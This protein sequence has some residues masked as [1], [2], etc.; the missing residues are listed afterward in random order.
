MIERFRFGF[1]HLN[2]LANSIKDHFNNQLQKATINVACLMST[3]L[4]IS[5]VSEGEVGEGDFLGYFLGFLRTGGGTPTH[6]PPPTVLNS[7]SMI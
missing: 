7:S 5:H 1:Q 3:P 6:H 4:L 2:L